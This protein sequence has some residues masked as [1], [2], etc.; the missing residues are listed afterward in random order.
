MT[1]T[2][3]DTVIFLD[4]DFNPQI[5]LQ[6]AARVHRIGQTK[7]VAIIRLV[8]KNTVEEII[9]RRT[10]QK[11]RSSLKIVDCNTELDD[12]ESFM[13]EIQLKE[14]L[15]FGL[16]DVWDCKSSIEDQDIENIMKDAYTVSDPKIN[17]AENKID[18]LAKVVEEDASLSLYYYEGVDLKP[19]N[20]FAQDVFDDD[21]GSI[22]NDSKQIFDQLVSSAPY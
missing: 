19:N 13:N 15:S 12:A 5:D 20:S 16:A 7:P 8:V 3:A 17:K 4:T 22:D 11:M 1:L 2:S 21:L 10:L 14:A 9:F 6:A 18:T